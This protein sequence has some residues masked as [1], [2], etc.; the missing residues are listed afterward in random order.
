MP[1]NR[2]TASRDG[3]RTDEEELERSAFTHVA[4]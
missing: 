2:K 3:E 4:F 1:W